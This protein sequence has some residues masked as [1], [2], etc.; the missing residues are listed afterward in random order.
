MKI[1]TKTG[2]KGSTG[3]LGGTRVE[4]N[5][6]R[7][8]IYGTFD[9]LTSF[10]GILKNQDIEDIHK[11]EIEYIQQNMIQV[12]AIFAIDYDNHSELALK[13]TFD[14]SA[15]TYLEEK[16]DTYTQLM[17]PLKGF[18]IPGET[19][20]SAYCDAC[21]TICRRAERRIYDITL[22][23]HQQNA[24]IFINRLSDFLYVLARKLTK[25]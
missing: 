14:T 3:L 9:E 17:P 16:I 4:K 19:L 5:D 24:A 12:N 13:Y 22:H 11:K 20:S 25:L 18:V 1:H 8:E 10:L 15:I 21:R 7:L 6:P 23:P 2:D